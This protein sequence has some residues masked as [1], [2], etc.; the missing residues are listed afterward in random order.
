MATLKV[1]KPAVEEDVVLKPNRT[2]VDTDV[3]ARD[4]ISGLVGKG[5]ISLSDDDSRNAYNRLR[6]IYGDP[7]AQKVM[8]QIS[9]FNQRP[10]LKKLP[11][12]ERI[13]KFYT[14]GSSNPLAQE[15]ISRGNNLSYGVLPAFR[16]SPYVM[17]QELQGTSAAPISGGDEVK[18][19]VMLKLGK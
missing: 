1:K 12:E 10:E 5:Y 7:K 14:I 17:N 16:N 15:A 13:S 18:K 3:E 11:T 6:V 19:K 8:Q 2:S 4:I 9:I